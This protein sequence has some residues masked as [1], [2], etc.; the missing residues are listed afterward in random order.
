MLIR[1][2]ERQPGLLDFQV[3]LEV[4]GETDVRDASR[5]SLEVIIFPVAV[6]YTCKRNTPTTQRLRGTYNFVKT[7]NNK[8]PLLTLCSEPVHKTITFVLHLLNTG[9]ATRTD[10][11]LLCLQQRIVQNWFVVVWESAAK[12]HCIHDRTSLL[13]F[14]STCSNEFPRKKEWKK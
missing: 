10:L 5:G 11:N 3:N 7:N 13:P 4:G 1:L 2:T 12:Q 14:C 9:P 6:P 8:L